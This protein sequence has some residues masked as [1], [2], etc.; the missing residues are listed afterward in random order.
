MQN[1][2]KS[3]KIIYYL[4]TSS[5]NKFTDLFSHEDNEMIR[6]LLGVLQMNWVLS[7]LNIYEILSTSDIK[8]RET[9][10]FKM[11]RFY[12]SPGAIFESA[13]RVLFFQLL[14]YN[15]PLTESEISLFDTWFEINKNKEKTFILDYE[16]FKKRVQNLKS[17]NLVIKWITSGNVPEEAALLTQTQKL[18]YAFISLISLFVPT[19]NQFLNEDEKKLFK[20][21]IFLV[22]S[23]FCF[24]IEMD[25][26]FIEEYWRE[27]KINSLDERLSYIL[28]NS[29]DDV[30]NSPQIGTMS[31]FL[32]FQ[33]K[34]S[35]GLNRGAFRD[36]LHLI[37]CWHVNVFI[38]NDRGIYKF[39]RTMGFLKERII[40]ANIESLEQD[41]Y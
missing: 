38:T 41:E 10:I 25:N 40:L 13:T 30:F 9:I 22:F 6:E 16:D 29:F 31:S 27:K 34:Q 33:S 1:S 18:S 21:R 23:I 11:S 8:R 3:S 7:P 36:A 28:N 19:R 2:G 37:Y 24:G 15:S 5:I 20:L 14:Q 39:S 4:D 35:K 26:V 32:L 17:L 12:S